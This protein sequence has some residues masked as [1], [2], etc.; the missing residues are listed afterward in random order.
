MKNID[1]LL[2]LLLMLPVAAH[3][4]KPAT[5]EES[6][7][8]RS[9]CF[10]CH[11]PDLHESNFRLDV[12]DLALKGG[13][14]GD[15]PI[16]PGNSKES[17]LLDYISGD[18]DLQMPPEDEGDPLTADEVALVRRWIEQGAHWPDEVAG[19]AAGKK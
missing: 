2:V 6:V 7:D 8:F 15:R 3:A 1:R 19:E 16:V 5:A 12:R 11:G 17:A 18:G 4:A 13:D 14:F 10:D 9:Q